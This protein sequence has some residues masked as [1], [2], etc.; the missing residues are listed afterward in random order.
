M[1]SNKVLNMLARIKQAT[2]ELDELIEKETD[3]RYKLCTPPNVQFYAC[4]EFVHTIQELESFVGPT[5]LRYED[6]ESGS[7]H[8]EFRLNSVP[9]VIVLPV[10]KRLDA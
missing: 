4:P 7:R 10:D 9:C 1:L 8:Y 2:D 5:K 6:P 3:G